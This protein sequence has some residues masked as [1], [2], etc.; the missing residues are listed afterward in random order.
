MNLSLLLGHPSLDAIV[1]AS[2]GR[3]Y[4][5]ICRKEEYLYV[6]E[7]FTL[8]YLTCLLHSSKRHF[9]K[10]WTPYLYFS[11]L[12]AFSL[13][14]Y[15]PPFCTLLILHCNCNAPLSSDLLLLYLNFYFYLKFPTVTII[16]ADCDPELF[17]I[18]EFTNK[19]DTLGKHKRINEMRKM[20]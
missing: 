20:S 7:C 5:C 8:E 4:P 18:S 2:S 12:Q 6:M 13:T 3:L 11:H 16:H 14:N 10:I 1:G 19:I 9:V 15:G 17:V